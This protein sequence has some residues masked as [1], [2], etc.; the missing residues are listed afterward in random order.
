MLFSIPF[1]VKNKFCT[2]N[3]RWNPKTGGTSAGFHGNHSMSV[4][5]FLFLTSAGF[6]FLDEEHVANVC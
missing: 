5:G 2:E 3:I 1:D 4:V 6:G